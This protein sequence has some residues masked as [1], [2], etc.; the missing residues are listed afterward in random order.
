LAQQCL[1]GTEPQ[2]IGAAQVFAANLRTAHLR[3]FCEEALTQLFKDL[4]ERVRSEAAQCFNGFE[5][6]ELAEYSGLIEAFAQSP[7]FPA[8]H[9]WVIRALEETTSRLPDA[10]LLVCE[11]FLDTVGAAAAD[12]RTHSAADAATVSQLLVRVES[13]ATDKM[14]RA[15]CLDLIDRMTL[16]GAYGLNEALAEYERM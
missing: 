2:R 5:R 11:R 13:Q 10:T 9:Q 4:D 15:R 1:S 12:I 6:E 14:L 8:N 3:S 7:A 16:I